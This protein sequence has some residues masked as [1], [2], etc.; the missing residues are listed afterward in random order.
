MCQCG[1]ISL[2]TVCFA[3]TCTLGTHVN[4][5]TAVKIGTSRV[6]ALYVP[7]WSDLTCPHTFAYTH[8]YASLTCMSTFVPATN[9]VNWHYRVPDSVC[10]N[11]VRSHLSAHIR[12]G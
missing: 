7:M 10:V 1:L 9:I 11:T 12:S 2:H 4:I 3:Y 5:F 8:M 6:R